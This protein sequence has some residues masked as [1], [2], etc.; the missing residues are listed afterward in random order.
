MQ[1]KIGL[2]CGICSSFTCNYCLKKILEKIPKRLATADPWS[3]HVSLHLQQVSQPLRSSDVFTGHC[4]ELRQWKK[5]RKCRKSSTP[6]GELLLDGSLYLPEYNLLLNSPLGDT[7]P[8]D[9]HG[10]GEDSNLSAVIHCV[11]N[12]AVAEKL[13]LENIIPDGSG[14]SF[15][16][17]GGNINYT[18]EIKLPYISSKKKVSLQLMSTDTVLKLITNTQLLQFVMEVMLF[19]RNAVFNS[20]KMGENSPEIE[21]LRICQYFNKPLDKSVDISILLGESLPSS[22]HHSLL[23][24]RFWK[25]NKFS[26]KFSEKTFWKDIMSVLPRNGTSATRI[27]GSSG[28]VQMAPT[29]I[30]HDYVKQPGAFPRKVVAVKFLPNNLYYQC[31]YISPYTGKATNRTK[32]SPAHIGGIFK[33]SEN[34]LQRFPFLFDFVEFKI[35]S[36]IICTNLLAM[37]GLVIQPKAVDNEL[38][39]FTRVLSDEMKSPFLSKRHK[40]LHKFIS[41]SRHTVVTHPVGYHR[42]VFDKGEPILENKKCFIVPGIGTGCGR[43]GAGRNKFVVVLLDW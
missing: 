23:L 29:K 22:T 12:P 40:V 30:F 18:I 10:L 41:L 42:D 32:Y 7:G 33:V 27:G 37:T 19:K 38:K 14:A 28:K 13:Y 11:I 5:S 31:L 1:S 6:T 16:H 20:S 36:A 2:F 3:I 17:V 35:F 25:T 9:I 39:K 34:M 15:S 26:A 43:G 4:C 24:M 21:D 8:V